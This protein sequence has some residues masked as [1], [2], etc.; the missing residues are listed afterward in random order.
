VELDWLNTFLA[1]V[2]RGGFTA[3]A[4]Q[5][6]RSQSRVSAH[7]AALERQ[8][9]VRLI[10]R[11]RRPAVPTAAGEVFARHAREI[12]A[13]VG[14]AR[15]AIGALRGL[16]QRSLSLITTPCVGAA[17][18]PGV[19]ARLTTE[20]PGVRIEL[21]EHNWHDVERT[22]LADGAAMA[23][24]PTL[25]RPPTAGL[26]ERRL[27]CEPFRVIVADD[28]ELVRGGAPVPLERLVRFPLLVCRAFADGDSELTRALAGQ[29][30]AM[31]PRVSAD[32]PQTLVSLARAGVGA[33]VVNAVALAPLDVAGLVVLEL[34]GPGL[35]RAVSAYWTDVLLDTDTGRRLHRA[36]LDAP[37]PAGAEQTPARTGGAAAEPAVRR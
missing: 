27:W 25:D 13:G 28:H 8:L 12:V 36:V 37:V 34:D 30:L 29:G 24:L 17:V 9:G 16:E 26:R 3:A 32:S 35:R 15:A 19:L 7:I 4:A 20:R 11:D 23:V 31:A 6:H 1:V 5:V 22:A 14:S 21:L 2:D 18:F 33:A 10:D